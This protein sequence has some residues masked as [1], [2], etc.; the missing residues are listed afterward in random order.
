MGLKLSKK[1]RELLPDNYET[2]AQGKTTD[3]L[4]KTLAQVESAIIDSKNDLANDAK[5]IS[6]KKE[7]S[8]ASGT[9]KDSI[10]GGKAMVE[11]IVW[12]LK[13]R[14]AI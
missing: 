14:G 4:K 11:V 2:E 12:T 6:L 13:D 8:D 10:S 9:Y 5:V 3:E 1:M 7:L